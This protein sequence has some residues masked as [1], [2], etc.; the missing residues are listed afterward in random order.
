MIECQD[1]AG[2]CKVIFK[3]SDLGEVLSILIENSIEAFAMRKQPRAP[4]RDRILIRTEKD[5]AAMRLI[6]EDNG[7]GVP[8]ELGDRI[9]EKG[10]SGKS[11]D[12][13]FGLSYARDCVAR[14]G[15]RIRRDPIFRSGARIVVEI[16]KA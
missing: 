9:F 15:G 5:G 3:A 16:P 7:P 4:H 11:A 8:P 10:T 6:V 13:G 1:L 12:R 14:Y 2:P